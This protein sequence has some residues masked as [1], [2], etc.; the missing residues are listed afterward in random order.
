MHSLQ[1]ILMQDLV[2]VGD[3]ACLA[4][5]TLHSLQRESFVL[6]LLSFRNRNRSLST[7]SL[8]SVCTPCTDSTEEKQLKLI[9]T[10]TVPS[11]RIEI[12]SFM[13]TIITRELQTMS[14][15]CIGSIFL[16]YLHSKVKMATT[17]IKTTTKIQKISY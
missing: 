5:V 9:L 13:K 14:T 10:F 16:C 2:L 6:S 17:V 15:P 4:A 11:T 3:C 1:Q 8:H 12:H 7:H